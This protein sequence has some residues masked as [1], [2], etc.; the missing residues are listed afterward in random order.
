MQEIQSRRSYFQIS[1][2]DF[3]CVRVQQH[4][5]THR[6]QQN[7]KTSELRPLNTCTV[8]FSWSRPSTNAPRCLFN[9]L[10]TT[11]SNIA[12]LQRTHIIENTMF[13][14]PNEQNSDV[15]YTSKMNNNRNS[16]AQTGSR[17]HMRKLCAV[18]KLWLFSKSDVW[19]VLYSRF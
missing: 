15:K 8:S 9:R 7:S 3:A 13:P 17:A 10:A 11:F 6:T 12:S 2:L 19:F 16:S 1:E 18:L 4:A 14:S 5:S